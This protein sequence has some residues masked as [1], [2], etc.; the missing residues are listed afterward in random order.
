MET[1]EFKGVKYDLTRHPKYYLTADADKR[2]WFDVG[3][4]LD[5]KVEL[6][7]DDVYEVIEV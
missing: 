1:D 5:H 3:K 6:H 2:N 7:P 4:Y